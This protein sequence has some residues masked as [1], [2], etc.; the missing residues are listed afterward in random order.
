MK[1]IMFFVI[2]ATLLINGCAN[3]LATRYWYQEGKSLEECQ[4]D[5]IDCDER[6]TQMVKMDWRQYEGNFAAQWSRKDSL[7]S[8]YMVA[9][10][11]RFLP[12]EQLA[13]GIRLTQ[14]PGINFA[15]K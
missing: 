12:K 14:N 2:P 5:W 10:G 4:Q 1:R 7:R 3:I 8:Q 13:T 15:G 11:Y 9:M 6:A